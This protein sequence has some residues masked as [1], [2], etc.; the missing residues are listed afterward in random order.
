MKINQ[1]KI[2]IRIRKLEKAKST[3]CGLDIRGLTK[4]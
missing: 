2:K 3:F 1:K 4:R